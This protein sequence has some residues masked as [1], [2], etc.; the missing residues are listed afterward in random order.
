MLECYWKVEEWKSLDYP[1]VDEVTFYF[2]VIAIYVFNDLKEWVF[3][4]F[5]RFTV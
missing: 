1:L 2:T 4:R 5:S 3:K